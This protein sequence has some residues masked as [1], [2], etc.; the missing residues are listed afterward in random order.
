MLIYVHHPA[1]KGVQ[2]KKKLRAHA[3]LQPALFLLIV[4][5]KYDL[6]KFDIKQFNNIPI[7]ITLWKVRRVG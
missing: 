5:P 3:S 2:F 6:E 7:L 1:V 4:D